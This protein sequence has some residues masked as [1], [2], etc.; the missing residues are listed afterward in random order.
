MVIIWDIMNSIIGFLTK[1]RMIQSIL[2]ILIAFIMFLCPLSKFQKLTIIVISFFILHH[3]A[4]LHIYLE[5]EKRGINGIGKLVSCE[6]RSVVFRKE[7]AGFIFHGYYNPEIMFYIA[8]IKYEDELWGVFYKPINME[9]LRII[10]DE[11][12]GRIISAEPASKRTYIIHT[13]IWCM[14]AFIIITA[15]MLDNML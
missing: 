9:E 11:E 14:I 3:I 5:I 10:Y 2:T 8:D 12:S 4:N 6:S 1:P 15:A 7:L 13:L